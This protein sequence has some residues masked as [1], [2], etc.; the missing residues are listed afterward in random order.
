MPSRRDVRGDDPVR[1]QQGR[2]RH[3]EVVD[4]AAV[5]EHP[6]I[7]QRRLDGTGEARGRPDRL[8]EVALVDDDGLP[9]LD[10]RRG[11][12]QRD[13][14]VLEVGR[15]ELGQEGL[16]LVALDEA[17]LERDIYDVPPTQVLGQLVDL[18]RLGT[19]SVESAHDRAHRGARDDVEP[20]PCSG[21]DPQHAYVREGPGA[22]TREHQ[23]HTDICSW[24]LHRG[25]L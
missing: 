16:E 15:Q 10:V 8:H 4:D 11:D 13:V 6:A 17:R 9:G 14:E 18:V 2:R 5:G 25:G 12:G 21:E 7:Q 23:A 20:G 1:P 22:T 3:R 19:G 24:T